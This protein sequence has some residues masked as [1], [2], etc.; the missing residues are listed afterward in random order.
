[1]FEHKGNEQKQSGVENRDRQT[2]SNPTGMPDSMKNQYEAMSGLSLEDVRVHYHSDKPARL[3]AMA[4]AQGSH[5]YLGPGQERQL[6]HELGHVIQQKTGSVRPTGRL[7]STDISISSSLEREADGYAQKA[8]SHESTGLHRPLRMRPRVSNPVVQLKPILDKERGWPFFVDDQHMDKSKPRFLLMRFIEMDDYVAFQ[9]RDHTDRIFWKK[10]KEWE[11]IARPYRILPVEA[12]KRT[13]PAAEQSGETQNPQ[14]QSSQTSDGPDTYYTD[15]SFTTQF[16]IAGFLSRQPLNAWLE[17]YREIGAALEKELRAIDADSHLSPEAKAVQKERQ[18]AALFQYVFQKYIV[19]ALFRAEE[20]ERMEYSGSPLS[21]QDRSTYMRSG[22][23]S[24]ADALRALLLNPGS[25]SKNVILTRSGEMRRDLDKFFLHVS[26]TREMLDNQD[27]NALLA[28]IGRDAIDKIAQVAEDEKGDFDKYTELASNPVLFVDAT[29]L[30]DTAAGQGDTSGSAAASRPDTASKSGPN[31]K[32]QD[33]ARVQELT[34]GALLRGVAINRGIPTEEADVVWLAGQPKSALS[35]SLFGLVTEC[36]DSETKWSEFSNDFINKKN[37]FLNEKKRL[38]D[39]VPDKKR[40][41]IDQIIRETEGVIA[42]VGAVKGGAR[43]LTDTWKKKIAPDYLDWKKE[44]L[45]KEDP[46][47]M[48]ILSKISEN[49]SSVAVVGGMI[50]LG[51]GDQPQS[52]LLVEN[53]KLDSYLKTAVNKTGFVPSVTESMRALLRY[54][55]EENG[56]SLNRM[57]KLVLKQQKDDWSKRGIRWDKFEPLLD[58]STPTQYQDAD[59]EKGLEL[60]RLLFTRF[61]HELVCTETDM[62]PEKERASVQASAVQKLITGSHLFENKLV[63]AYVWYQL[64][65][66]L[67][68]AIYSW[69]RLADFTRYIQSIHEI[70]LLGLDL[71]G[72]ES[73]EQAPKLD[74][75]WGEMSASPFYQGFYLADYGLKAFAQV[76]DAAAEQ[77]KAD[78]KQTRTARENDSPM[79]IAAF[80]NIYF[81]LTDKLRATTGV[82]NREV[83]LS[84]PENVADYLAGLKD[85]NSLPDIVM[86]DIHPNDASKRTIKANNVEELLAGLAAKN[87]DEEMGKKKITVMVDITLNQAADEEVQALRE[88]ADPYISDGWLNLVFVQS[89]TKFAQMGMDK[90]SGGLIFSFNNPEKWE[91]YNDAL[92]EY[93]SRD[94]VDPSVRKYFTLLFSS[95]PEEQMLYLNIIRENT[96]YVQNTLSA[97][98]AGTAISLTPNT[99]D[100]SCY[101]AWR[102]EKSHGQITELYNAAMNDTPCVPGLPEEIYDLHQFNIAVLEYGINKELSREKLPVAMRFSFGFPLSNLGETGNEVRFTIGMETHAELD[103]YIEVISGIAW[104][105]QK[106]INDASAE[107]ERRKSAHSGTGS[108]GSTASAPAAGQAENTSSILKLVTLEKLKAYLSEP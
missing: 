98:L 100:K 18:R 66:Y 32:Q 62:P 60:A 75:R 31:K 104:K 24:F 65:N 94:P 56:L 92:R 63:P 2:F 81:E 6:G 20:L 45:T 79:K 13:R 23:G 64:A 91:T 39:R 102:Y 51:N 38:R 85:Q 3:G 43:Q 50:E 69:K 16:D 44:D 48:A 89:L 67:E 9:I 25:T 37:A 74:S 99:D 107:M 22:A 97:K 55:G 10:T 49:V 101:V 95:I 34:R 53:T 12:D 17:E 90:H 46:K 35:E 36:M 96:R 57:A 11:E 41:G 1:M 15:R 70:I 103:E 93:I 87:A 86:I 61:C 71:Q 8:K 5:I 72:D 73:P 14:T 52:A 80:Y 76:Y 19:N 88:A 58:A 78:R 83:R 106:L 33:L 42:A 54:G 27:I 84:T 26:I 40:G 28:S 29:D 108:A 82:N 7:L 105:L 21:Y 68:A 4:C 47:S 30:W 59:R 77:Y